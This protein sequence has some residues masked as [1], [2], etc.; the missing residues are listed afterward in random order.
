M[1]EIS[2]AYPP[3]SPCWYDLTVT[4]LAGAKT[5]YG[6][7]FGWDF[8]NSDWGYD[9]AYVS[10]HPVAALGAGV[11]QGPPAW[12]VYLA[13][14]DV[15]ATAR[16]VTE[17]GGTVIA[18]PHDAPEGRLAVLAD[19]AGGY[20]GVWQG[21]TFAGAGTTGVPGAPCWAEASSRRPRVTADF[22]G[23][24]FGLDVRRPFPGYEYA[25]LSVG[26]RAVTGVLGHTHEHRPA[27]QQ[28]AWLVYFQVADADQAAR[29]AASG[30]ATVLQQP[31]DT[32]FGRF[33][34]LADPWGARLAVIT[35]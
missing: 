9:R 23:T 16:A 17:A 32:P 8:E 22:L 7:L 26:D 12:T 10:G 3:G 2:G 21:V 20:F 34:V 5:F 27:E 13:T 29:T 18:A 1:T 4:D 31:E 15:E 35:R 33:A 25:Q 28:A 14:D 11:P 19:P 30:G 24:V 6:A